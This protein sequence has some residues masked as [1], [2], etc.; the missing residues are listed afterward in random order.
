VAGSTNALKGG[1]SQTH[2]SSADV[3]GTADSAPKA[4]KCERKQ[5]L[6]LPRHRSKYL[7]EPDECP[8]PIKYVSRPVHEDRRVGRKQKGVRGMK[9][10]LSG[11]VSREFRVILSAGK[12]VSKISAGVE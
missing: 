12:R 5:A 9:R 7:A 2:E 11:E 3:R 8:T 10:G 1:H 4:E 6:V